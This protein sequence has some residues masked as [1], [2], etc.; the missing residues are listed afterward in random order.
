MPRVT[1]LD[2]SL[3]VLETILQHRNGI[4]TR[5]ITHLLGFNV[6]TVH[7]IAMTFCHRGY[8]RQNPKTKQFLPGM[9]LAMLGRHPSHLEFLTNSS[10]EIV[11]HLSEQLNE[12]VFLGT[13]DYGQITGLHYVECQQAL[14]VH[15]SEDAD[16][17]PYTTA[18]GKVLLASLSEEELEHYLKKTQLR[19]FTD[20]T[21]ATPAALREELNK[22]RELGY[23]KTRDEYC[24]GISAIGIPIHDAWGT[25]FASIGASAPTVRMQKEGIVQKNL[26]AL[27]KAAK[28]IE[29]IWNEAI[30]A[31]SA[32][33]P[34]L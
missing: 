14:R 7:N 32:P 29:S 21:I 19:R 27:Q 18:Y 31:D 10:K 1:S 2:K 11:T 6:A 12:N 33:K 28:A 30:H 9:R 23:A 16:D 20:R 26:T 15:Q 25:I 17:H 24:D 34:T 8:L 22:V 13:I 4:G 5:A 3:T